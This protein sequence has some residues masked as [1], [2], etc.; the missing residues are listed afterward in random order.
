MK[1]EASELTQIASHTSPAPTPQGRATEPATS[2]GN[3]EKRFVLAHDAAQGLE[4]S[5]LQEVRSFTRYPKRINKPESNEQRN[6]N[7]FRQRLDKNI[8]CMNEESKT[9][10]R[11]LEM[12]PTRAYAQDL[13]AKVKRLGRIPKELNTTEDDESK[14]EHNLARQ[15]R[16]ARVAGAFTESEETELDK[17]AQIDREKQLE[18]K[19]LVCREYAQ[20]LMHRIR[21]LGRLPK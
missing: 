8:S 6:E 7:N 1:R 19:K 16:D 14:V 2:E 4:R 5:L 13:L 17:L 11:T 9:Y 15:L 21:L 20:E 12:L 18:T 10:L 3:L